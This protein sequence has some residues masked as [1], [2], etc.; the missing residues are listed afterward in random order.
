MK[1]R[2]LEWIVVGV[3]GNCLAFGMRE[4]DS[5]NHSK[6]YFLIIYLKPHRL[7][8]FAGF[9]KFSDSFGSFNSFT[10]YP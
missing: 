4:T 10:L 6:G 5:F 2:A 9:L 7:P 1:D 3:G 8:N